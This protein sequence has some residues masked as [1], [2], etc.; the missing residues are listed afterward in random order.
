MT[1]SSF[2]HL[3]SFHSRPAFHGNASARV[4]SIPVETLNHLGKGSRSKWDVST[5]LRYSE[6]ILQWSRPESVWKERKTTGNKIVYYAFWFNGADFNQSQES[7]VVSVRMHSKSV[8]ILRNRE[9]KASSKGVYCRKS[10]ASSG[11]TDARPIHCLIQ[12]PHIAGTSYVA[13]VPCTPQDKQLQRTTRS[14][15]YP[16]RGVL[17]G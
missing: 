4:I 1:A 10:H 8:S 11:T 13:G 5:A 2:W 14:G 9:Q 7:T 12:V 3:S 17:S 16:F 15:W 6:T